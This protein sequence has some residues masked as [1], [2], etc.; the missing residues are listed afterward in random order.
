M[1]MYILLCGHPPFVSDVENDPLPYTMK[2]NILA[3]NVSFASRAWGGVSKQAKDLVS[4]LLTVDPAQRPTAE[5]LLD[6]PWVSRGQAPST[7]LE[8]ARHAPEGLRRLRLASCAPVLTGPHIAREPMTACTASELPRTL[9]QPAPVVDLIQACEMPPPGDA[10]YQL[11]Q[12]QPK[13]AVCLAA[14]SQANVTAVLAALEP[15]GWNATTSTFATTTLTLQEVREALQ[16]A[17]YV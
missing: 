13:V 1:I 3:A 5:Q 10:A 4:K 12:L 9:Q 17:K 8:T 16:H 15:L 7:P 14:L 11:L 6:D 2:Q